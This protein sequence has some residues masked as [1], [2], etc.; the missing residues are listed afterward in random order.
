VKRLAVI[1]ALAA[2]AA[3]GSGVGTSGA[4]FTAHEASTGSVT[5]ASDWVAPSLTLTA[6]ADGSSRNSTTVTVS[7]AAGNAAGDDTTVNLN[8]YSGSTATGTPILTRAVTRSGATWSTTL[9]GLGQATYTAQ[10]TQTDS[11]S[12]TATTPAS[13][14]TVDTTAP[15]RVSMA[16][17]NGTGTAGHLDA[18]DTITF[19]YSERMLPSSIL[20]GWSGTG[21]ASVKVR[22]FNAGNGD[23]FTIL[24]SAGAATLKLDNGTAN[25]P[26]GVALGSSA[27]YVTNT[28]TFSATMTQS[29]DGNSFAIVLGSP[30]LPSRVVSTA[31]TAKSMTWTPKAGATDVAGN[32][33]TNTASWTETDTDR[34]F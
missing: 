29:A 26:G 32:A 18:G 14:F 25:G 28:V 24:D 22:F 31:V 11:S 12:N 33:L 21:A 10:A 16:A 34:D 23:S 5:T 20:S 17:T 9:T 6:P 1:G 8:L 7:G 4:N 19:T 30:D 27:N 13:T 15:T 2:L 3:A